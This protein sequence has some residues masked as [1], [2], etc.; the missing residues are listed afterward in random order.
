MD[1]LG[2]PKL[3]KDLKSRGMNRVTTEFAIE[4]VV[5]LEQ[6]DA[7]TSP[8]QQQREHRPGR[9]ASGDAAT[10]LVILQNL[11]L[12]GSI[13]TLSRCHRSFSL[14]LI[15]W[16]VAGPANSSAYRT[17]ARSPL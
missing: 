5:H 8:R 17:R 14:R 13:E 7:H 11:S 10:R 2:E 15:S 3:I 6:S 9:S 1:T 12:D 4:I 16:Q